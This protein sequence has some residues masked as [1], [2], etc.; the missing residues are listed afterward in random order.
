MPRKLKHT[1]ADLRVYLII[2]LILGLIGLLVAIIGRSI[3]AIALIS[4]YLF[5]LG[6]SLVSCQS[7]ERVSKQKKV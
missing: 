2:G 5:W 6:Y 1:Y 3:F 7:G 4:V